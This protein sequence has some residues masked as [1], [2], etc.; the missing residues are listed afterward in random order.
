[1]AINRYPGIYAFNRDQAHIF[2]GREDDTETLNTLVQTQD[3]V[4]LY[5]K[6]GLGKSSLINAGLLPMLTEQ[7]ETITI[8]F[9]AYNESVSESPIDKVH[10]QIK[11][12]FPSLAHDNLI[13]R[14]NFDKNN[15][16]ALMKKVQLQPAHSDKVFLLVFDQFEELFSYPDEQIEGFKN[17]LYDL[18]LKRMPGKYNSL[19]STARKHPEIALSRT[20]AADL[21]SK[22][23][24]KC[25]F[26]IRSDRL[27]LLNKLS[28]KLPD[29]QKQFYELQPL[30]T[31]QTR[32]AITA[33]AQKKGNFSS[34][35]FNYAP[36]ATE[37]I[38]KFLTNNYTRHAE[39]TQMQIICKTIEEQSATK[40]LVKTEDV[41]DFKNVFRDFYQN[42]LQKVAADERTKARK[43]IEDEMIRN[44]QRI[45]LDGRICTEYISE[46]S[47][48]KLTDSYLIRAERNTTGNYSYEL[49]HDSLIAPI[50]EFAQLRRHKEEEEKRL[51]AK[52]AELKKAK[53]K[54]MRMRKIIVLVSVAAIMAIVLAAFAFLSGQ[55]AVLMEKRAHTAIFDF[56]V[57]EHIPDWEGF[58]EYK[59][60]NAEEILSQIDSLDLSNKGLWGLPIELTHCKNIRFLN[61]L[62]NDM[63]HWDTHNS[64]EVLDFLSDKANIYITVSNLVLF[65]SDYWPL[66]SG[67]QYTAEGFSEIPSDVF[68]LPHIEYLDISGYSD[69]QNYLDEILTNI[70]ELPK[71]KHFDAEYCNIKYVSPSVLAL[72][73]LEYLNLDHNLLNTLPPEISQLQLLQNLFL[74]Y[75]QLNDLPDTYS[76][77]NNLHGLYLT[78]NNFSKLPTALS[79]ME[80]LRIIALGGNKITDITGLEKNKY[81]E[82][83][84]LWENPISD[85]PIEIAQ[86]PY[87]RVLNLNETKLNNEAF[88]EFIK[89]CPKPVE[90][91]AN[92]KKYYNSDPSVLRITV[93]ETDA[94]WKQLPNVKIIE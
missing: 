41:P 47:L 12:A 7:Y 53:A 2:F 82:V 65:E 93:S 4:L 48:K 84:Y 62:G 49:S 76:D 21:Q 13:D 37:K 18:L 1:M 61:L 87:L 20:Q 90:I 64:T 63:I 55:D 17:S 5:S 22:I 91:T 10:R 24:L 46:A 51:Q 15:L 26:A 56:A 35:T 88:T 34:P 86:L 71:L 81:L 6:S 72:K 19:I 80:N 33:P 27:S 57:K 68:R 40:G 89:T 78:K 38:L 74:G 44:E 92:S 58:N 67:I 50:L 45:S 94:S 25:L 14:L 75:N 43:L 77:L 85:I 59:Q 9:T 79:G 8:R 60:D 70:A 42:A 52:N 83:I 29:I 31:E 39:S 28:D 16:W 66:I 36:E 54:Q 32:R 23:P 73:E 3:T 30:S 69:K 11:A